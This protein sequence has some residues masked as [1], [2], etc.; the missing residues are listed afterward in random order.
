MWYCGLKWLKSSFCPTGDCKALILFLF[1]HTWE[2]HSEHNGNGWKFLIN[3]KTRERGVEFLEGEQK[4]RAD[5]S[6]NSAYT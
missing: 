1:F 5:L 4:S 3:K 2:M 6:N